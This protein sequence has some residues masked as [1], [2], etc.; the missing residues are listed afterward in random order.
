MLNK[1]LFIV[2]SMMLDKHPWTQLVLMVALTVAVLV[3]VV[4]D[5]PYQGTDGRSNVMSE[6]DKQMAM[7]QILQLLSYA[8][9]GLCLRN[10]QDRLDEQKEGLSDSMQT[11]STVGAGVIVL[12]QLAV[13]VPAISKHLLAEADEERE[14]DEA[15]GT[16]QD[17]E[18][19]AFDNPLKH[20]H[21]ISGSQP[22]QVENTGDEV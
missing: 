6:G 8:L 19:N 12:A 7:S 17:V 14:I 9:A 20:S 4:L 16:D 21:L 5:K 2:F 18:Y 22:T 1:V 11:F 13:A 3:L 10:G 15:H